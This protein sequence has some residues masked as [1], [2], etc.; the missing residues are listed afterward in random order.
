[1]AAAN[2]LGTS[3]TLLDA[4][5][6]ASNLIFGGVLREIVCVHEIAS[7]DDNGSVYR[8][9]RLHSS[10]RLSEVLRF[11]DT[12]TS[13]ADFD[14]G[15]YETTENGGA[16]VDKDLLADGI[17]IATASNAGVRDHFSTIDKNKAEKTVWEMIATTVTTI[18][19]DPKKYYDLAYTG[20]TMGAAAGTL[21]VYTRYCDGT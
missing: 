19:A 5:K 18:T 13:A 6:R 1:M 21:V 9:A 3:I 8:V 2:G 12:L 14:V 4:G 20:T 15:F 7:A 17:S 10:W 16:A 11:N